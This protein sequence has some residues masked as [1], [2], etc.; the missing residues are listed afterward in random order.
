MQHETPVAYRWGRQ[1]QL[2]VEMGAVNNGS[3]KAQSGQKQ[4]DN[5]STDYRART[6]N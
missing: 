6:L 2:W 4:K 5:D 1:S 3:C